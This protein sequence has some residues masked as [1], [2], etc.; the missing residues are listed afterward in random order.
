MDTVVLAM[1]DPSHGQPMD[2][3]QLS[4]VNPWTRPWTTH[5]HPETCPP[6]THPG[7]LNPRM[8]KGHN[9]DPDDELERDIARLIAIHR[10][11]RKEA[12]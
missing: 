5:G 10:A 4:Q 1:H 11:R 12:K 9:D 2:T 6:W 8:S 7:G 3:E